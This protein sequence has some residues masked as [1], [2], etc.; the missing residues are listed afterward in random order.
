MTYNFDQ[1]LDRRG[2]HATKWDVGEGEL[3]MW[4]ADM[5]FPTAPEIQAAIQARAAHGIYGYTDIP[6]AWY[7]AICGWWGNRHGFRMERE[8]LLFSTGVVPTISSVV[9]KLTTPGEN[10]LTMTPVYDIYFHSIENNGRRVLECPLHYH[11]GV[12]EIDWEDLERKLADPQTTLMILCNP[13]NPVGKIWDRETLARI[14]ELCWDH[15]VLVLSDEIHCDLTLPGRDYTPFAAVSEHCR[16]NSIT[17]IAP[18]KTFNLAGLQTAAAAVPDPVLRHKVWR[19][20]NTD[21]VAEPNCFAAEA[22]VAAFI[23]GGPWLDALR[24][25]LAGN[26]RQAQAFLSREL[27]QVRAVDA[28]ATYLLWLDCGQAAERSE[29][30]AAF[31]RQKTGL[32]LSAGG[33][34]RGNGNQFLR[35]NIACPRSR[36]LDGLQRLREA[37]LAYGG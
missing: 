21:E 26:R 29:E 35:M 8:W 27:P 37:V 34:Y 3:P 10:V 1:I 7:D 30:L 31:I 32:Y 15:H 16:Q 2:T 9:R 13:H 22:A 25:Y 4:I 18:T 23:C 12:Y 5:D 11:N 24:A 33:V 6:E 19:A 20:L 36:L 17:C 28:E 14:G